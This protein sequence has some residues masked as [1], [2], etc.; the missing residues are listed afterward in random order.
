MSR[1]IKLHSSDTRLAKLHL[2]K[3]GR[4]DDEVRCWLS[5]LHRLRLRLAG[6]RAWEPR[7]IWQRD[8]AGT[9]RHLEVTRSPQT[10]HCLF[11]P[12]VGKTTTGQ[13]FFNMASVTVANEKPAE[14]KPDLYLIV[15]FHTHREHSTRSLLNL[16]RGRYHI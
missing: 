6:S 14:G 16:V 9:A 7:F 15:S 12:G 13:L 8:D 3:A 2:D 11:I 5:L 1:C 10:L 4:D